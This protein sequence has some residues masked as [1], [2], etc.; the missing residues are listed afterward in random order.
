MSLE[1]K[2]FSR[3]K[4]LKTAGTAGVGALLTGSHFQKTVSAATHPGDEG[5]PFR[6]FGRTG[7]SVPIIGFGGSQNLE[8]KQR[9]LRQAIKLGVTYWDTAESYTHGGSEKAMGK[10]LKKYP[11]D[12]K[13]LFLVTKSDETQPSG[14]SQSLDNSLKRLNSTYIDLFF[15]HSISNPDVMDK[16]IRTWAEQAKAEGKIRLIG[17][18]SHSN[19]E[20]CMIGAAK[21]GW[22]DGIMVTYNYRLMHTDNMKR[23]VEACVKAGIGLTAMKTQAGW[24]WRNVGEKTSKSEQLIEGYSK[25]GFT[26]EQAKLMAVWDNPHIA[27]ICSE[28]T[29]LKILTTNVAAA[30]SRTSLSLKDNRLLNQYALETETEYCAGCADNCESAL[31]AEVPVCQV[32]RYL[33]Y[34]RCYQEPERA[35]AFF[36]EMSPETRRR[37]GEIDYT[38][39]EAS[40]PRG[41]PIGRLMKEA[42]SELL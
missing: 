7:V 24:S 20:A 9:L 42:L 16:D 40:C 37:I 39:A 27:S 6:P 35:R 13:K 33:M 29:N 14:L 21:L 11:E 38:A 23:A 30:R 1:I 19:M 31:E 36:R 25:K 41:M 15:I 32:M 22:I 28:M 5:M 17:F 34:A 10:Y 26:K 2:V 4:F 8:S 18:S 3:R 12:R